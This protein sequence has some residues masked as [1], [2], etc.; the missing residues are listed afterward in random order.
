MK[1]KNT[2][3]AGFAALAVVFASC[4]TS[5]EIAKRHFNNGY[6]V[7]VTKKNTPVP[8]ERSEAAKHEVEAVVMQEVKIEPVTSAEEVVKPAVVEGEKNK[9]YASSD[10][11]TGIVVSQD[12]KKALVSAGITVPETTISESAKVSKADR[13][14]RKAARKEFRSMLRGDAPGIVLVLL[15]IFLPPVAV[16]IV[17]DWGTKFWFSLILWLLLILPGIIYAF[18]VCFA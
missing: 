17:D 7:H 4:S 9:T 6:Y 16:G 15:C 10:K 18:Y 5:V 14:E 11:K 1:T 2:L 12:L 13:S 8:A 3:V